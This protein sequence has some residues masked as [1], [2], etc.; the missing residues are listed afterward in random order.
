[1]A[2]GTISGINQS[3][4]GKKPINVPDHSGTVWT[5]YRITPQ[6]EIAGGVF[7]ASSR[8]ADNVNEVTLPGYARV[9]ASVSYI[10]KHF[11]LQ[12]N[13]FNL[14]DEKYYQSGQARSALP[15]V[16][17]TGQISVRLRF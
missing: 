6:W 5:S 10:H 3:L 1:M 16:P 2:V 11:T 13:V 9:D 12:G 4:Q 7:F 17:L 8:Y 15:G 14:F